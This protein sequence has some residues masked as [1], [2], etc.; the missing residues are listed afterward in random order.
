MQVIGYGTRV[1]G[2]LHRVRFNDHAQA[3]P[4][5]GFLTGPVFFVN[6]LKRH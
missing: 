6:V 1:Y 3:P 5:P 4:H 2:M